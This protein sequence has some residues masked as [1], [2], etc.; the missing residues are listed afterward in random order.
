MIRRLIALLLW[1]SPA[2]AQDAYTIRHFTN[3]S[4]LPVNT[5]TG[6]EWDETNGVVW[7]GTQAGLVRW[8]G[9]QFK[10]V[11][12]GVRI[13]ALDQKAGTGIRAVSDHAAYYL[14]SD[15]QLRARPIRKQPW[16]HP[17]FESMDSNLLF[18][19][20]TELDPN[21]LTPGSLAAVPS[22]PGQWLV[23][24][25]T[26]IYPL[27]NNSK[28]PLLSVDPNPGFFS[29][30]DSLLL[31]A[32]SGLFFF[33]PA[34]T[35]LKP[36]L[37]SGLPVDGPRQ[38]ITGCD[39]PYPMVQVREALYYLRPLGRGRL[40][41][42]TL[43]RNLPPSSRIRYIRHLRGEG[44][45]VLGD[46]QNGIYLLR[47]KSVR[48]LTDTT[49]TIDPI[50][51]PSY[52]QCVLLSGRVLTQSG[53][54]FDRNGLSGRRK[55]PGPSYQ[56]SDQ[57]DTVYLLTNNAVVAYHKYRG[58][59]RSI[60]IPD[61]SNW[62]IFQKIDGVVHLITQEAIYRLGNNGLREIFRFPKEKDMPRLQNLAVEEIEPGIFA[63]ASGNKLGIYDHRRRTLTRT[64]VARQ[65]PIRCLWKKDDCLFMGTYGEGIFVY[66]KGNV[67]PLLS[68]KN[69]LLQFCHAIVAD[70]KGYCF[71]T[72]NNGLLRVAESALMEGYSRQTQPYYHFFGEYDGLRNTEFNGGGQPAFVRL[73]DGTFSFPSMVGLNWVHPDSITATPPY[74]MR[75]VDSVLANGKT[76]GYADGKQFA[77]GTRELRVRLSWNYWGASEN[78]YAW[79]RLR[80]QDNVDSK[81]IPFPSPFPEELIF[82]AL[83]AG[84]YVLEIRNIGGYTSREI[85]TRAI[86]FTIMQPWYLR[87][88]ALI[89]WT[90]AGLSLMLVLIRL[91]FR[92]VMRQNE[93]L[94]ALVRHRTYE[95]TEKNR[96]LEQQVSVLSRAN[97]LKE[98][99]ISVI[100]HNI[101]TPLRYIHRTTR[102]MRESQARLSPALQQKAVASINDTSIELEILAINLL[103]WIS[104]QR[105]QAEATPEA[106]RLRTVMQHVQ[107]LLEP[108]AKERQT[109][110]LIGTVADEP[111]IQY[112]D[113]LQVIL[114][115]LVLNAIIHAS[116]CT[117]RMAA[118]PASDGLCSFLISDDGRGMT[119][120]KVRKLLQPET[121]GA[122]PDE[123]SN[124]G[125]GFGFLIIH[126]LLQQIRGRMEIQSQPGKGT[127][128]HITF[129]AFLNN[130][131]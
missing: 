101:I 43:C 121:E 70:G 36:L 42:E 75:R 131:S 16:L 11:L 25:K 61:V 122:V 53:L 114:Y 96:Q 5:V 119:T 127:R 45:I 32:R 13:V 79:Y 40:H 19:S 62:A 41:A 88:P 89:A 21:E 49:G 47:R 55:M 15:P 33:N 120:E 35:T 48:Q 116:P 39:M 103:N 26:K 64:A 66:R 109:Q 58:T 18:R 57:G 94:Q 22:K 100:S 28:K 80:K 10:T 68:D 60:Q 83:S 7:I 130:Q 71:L 72:T 93:R 102:V 107:G 54:I 63:I 4:G 95:V 105:E 51:L 76:E 29:V 38:L 44:C 65:A 115:N 8:N 27:V 31:A 110:I 59:S 74:R 108:I 81:W 113:A 90:L 82:S 67:S 3:R 23:E 12:P 129:P 118:L 98:R 73:P 125:H 85:N 123:L 99:L 56:M 2:K 20:I 106:L 84:N 117:V 52:S 1:A 126:D 87:M 128:I 111:L 92:S 34:D 69:N 112:R 24:Y 17:G 97:R 14:L 124:Q 86:R 104:L 6:L 77:S 30:G 50:L 91:R 46:A 78:L 37:I 9:Q